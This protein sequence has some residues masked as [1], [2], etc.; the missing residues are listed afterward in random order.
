MLLNRYV[1]RTS[2]S[3]IIPTLGTRSV[4]ILIWLPLHISLI[5]AIE[6]TTAPIESGSLQHTS[7][8]SAWVRVAGPA[9]VHHVAKAMAAAT[10][11]SISGG[12]SREALNADG[13]VVEKG[14]T[15]GQR[16]EDFARKGFPRK[17]AD[18]LNFCRVN[19]IDDTVSNLRLSSCFAFSNIGS[20]TFG[21]FLSPRSHCLDMEH[22]QCWIPRNGFP[23][24]FFTH[25]NKN[26]KRLWFSYG[27]TVRGLYSTKARIF[28]DRCSLR[29]AIYCWKYLRMSF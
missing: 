13:F 18:G 6:L 17:T 29:R 22:T 9:T 26:E 28:V 27:V 12:L 20:S 15:F 3:S 1:N 25:E 11:V 8:I 14:S 16:V 19:V 23:D 5:S 24:S 21:R 4:V 2:I 10:P 7:I